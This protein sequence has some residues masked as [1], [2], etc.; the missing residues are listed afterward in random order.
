M[1]RAGIP[2]KVAMAISGH[3]TESIYRRY[4]IVAHRDLTD[5]AFRLERYFG[6]LK[7]DAKGTLTGT[8]ETGHQREEENAW[9]E[10]SNKLLN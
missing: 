3:K 9:T 1:E 10:K 2:R 8:P 4:D 5:A 6:T 7:E